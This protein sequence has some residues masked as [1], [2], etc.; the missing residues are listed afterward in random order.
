MDNIKLTK[1][2]TI[3]KKYVAF[4]L[5]Y[6]IYDKLALKAK[7]EYK[8]ISWVIQEMLTKYL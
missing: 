2:G 8:T 3:Q 7:N 1:R 5:N 6:I 4:K